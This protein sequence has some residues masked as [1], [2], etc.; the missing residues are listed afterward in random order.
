LI[1][2]PRLPLLE[3]ACTEPLQRVRAIKK[4]FF[5]C[6]AG[7]IHMDRQGKQ[8]KEIAFMD[9]REPQVVL[10]DIELDDAALDPYQF[11][12]YQRIAR[13]CAGKNTGE[14][15]E[16]LEIMATSCKMSSSQLKRSLR[17]LIE[18]R[19]I[20]R[21]SEPGKPSHYAL[22]DKKHWITFA[23]WS[24]KHTNPALPEPPTQLSQSYH[25]ALPEPHPA[26]PELPPG[27]DRADMKNTKK[28]T[29]KENKEEHTGAGEPDDFDPP[30]STIDS[31][32]NSERD[33]LTAD[34][35][36]D[37]IAAY[38]SA[39][40][41]KPN[42]F[43]QEQMRQVTDLEVWKL[44]LLQWRTNDWSRKNLFK[45]IEQY[46]E[47]VIRAAQNSMFNGDSNGQIHRRYSDAGSRGI[48]ALRSYLTGE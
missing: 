2:L 28:N 25:P 33:Y 36:P 8:A 34:P 35:L 42:N 37:V 16:K 30:F 48:E 21:R 27:S 9:E 6:R 12:A 44:T 17:V 43:Q 10:Y 47:N 19:M 26:L 4:G 14:C 20:I 40:N 46:K 39:F 23:E 31:E 29:N 7:R 5:V 18:R 22:L 41:Q 32:T 45:M 38:E 1:A 11:R 24:K 3:K 13:R 15:F